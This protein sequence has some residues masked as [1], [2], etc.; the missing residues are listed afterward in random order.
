MLPSCSS[1][2]ALV[3]GK[4]G[5]EDVLWGG[6]W[7]LKPSVALKARNLLKIRIARLSRVARFSF[8]SHVKGTQSLSGVGFMRTLWANQ[9]KDSIFNRRY[10]H[11][12]IMFGAHV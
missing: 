11:P 3:K 8:R 1:R 2:C 7:D 10:I 4:K 6:W 12:T 9:I 5:T